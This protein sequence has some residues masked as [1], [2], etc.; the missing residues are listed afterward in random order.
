MSNAKHPADPESRRSVFLQQGSINNT[1]AIPEGQDPGHKYL[2]I[3]EVHV[4]Q[5]LQQGKE[6]W[7]VLSNGSFLPGI[8][9]FQYRP[10][11][12]ELLIAH[13]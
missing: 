1:P 2:R 5:A 11:H 13:L 8:R 12:E 9:F 10:F 3:C 7:F 4:Y 6:C